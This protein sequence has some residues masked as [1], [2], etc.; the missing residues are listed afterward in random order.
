MYGVVEELIWTT[1]K[2][3]VLL[4]GGRLTPFTELPRRG[5][6]ANSWVGDKAWTSASLELVPNYR[7]DALQ[8]LVPISIILLL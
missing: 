3:A 2:D 5:L 8:A 4:V 7:I 6:R 1:E